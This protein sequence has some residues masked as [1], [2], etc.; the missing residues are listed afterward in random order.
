MDKLGK[1][2]V[3]AICIIVSGGGWGCKTTQPGIFYELQRGNID[4]YV[5][6]GA[7]TRE[8]VINYFGQTKQ[9]QDKAGA[10]IWK[11]EWTTQEERT[12]YS[13]RKIGDERSFTSNILGYS[14][15]VTR[16]T[17]VTL[18]FN[19]LGVLQKHQVLTP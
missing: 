13:G 2:I 10:E 6:D 17:I 9:K 18:V 5:T 16:K 1:A 14:H 12:A 7:T 11:Y 8:D 19:P 3:I 4:K 15:Y